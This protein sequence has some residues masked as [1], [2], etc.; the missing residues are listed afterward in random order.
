[1]PGPRASEVTA[2]LEV[3]GEPQLRSG[4]LSRAQIRAIDET[5]LL[6]A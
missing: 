6:T 2:P 3:L 1:M 4:D 5:R